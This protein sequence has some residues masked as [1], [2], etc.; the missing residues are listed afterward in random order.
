MSES[1]GGAPAN[2]LRRALEGADASERL[3]VAL[4]AGTRP[5]ASYIEV[6]VQR[7]EVEPDF[8]VRDM[9]T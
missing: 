7:C 9:L 1:H 4:T 8:F 6:L 3:Q 5:D 2:R